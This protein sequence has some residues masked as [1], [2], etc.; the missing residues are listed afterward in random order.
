M[1]HPQ[2]SYT[3]T[4]PVHM[5]LN[6]EQPYGKASALVVDISTGWADANPELFLK[7]VA[8]FYE[9]TLGWKMAVDTTRDGFITM[10]ADRAPATNY[11]EIRKDVERWLTLP[12]DQTW[13]NLRVERRASLQSVFDD[14]GISH[15]NE[16]AD[17]DAPSLAGV[18]PLIRAAMS[19]H[20]APH[21]T[22]LL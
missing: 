21:G 20:P 2:P 11:D 14:L 10:R 3:A 18:E 22:N 4:F 1:T 7:Y 6:G 17:F 13:R 5:P 19:R 16:L 12:E 8:D 15:L 9:Q